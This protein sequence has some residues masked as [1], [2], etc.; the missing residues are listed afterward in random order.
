MTSSAVS[1]YFSSCVSVFIAMS[2]AAACL[3]VFRINVVGHHCG[4][5]AIEVSQDMPAM[6]LDRF[7]RSDYCDDVVCTGVS[8][9]SVSNKGLRGVWLK[10]VAV[11]CL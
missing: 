7:I 2:S 3:V 9:R 10:N 4:T 11:S 6:F 1:S 8:Y 5:D